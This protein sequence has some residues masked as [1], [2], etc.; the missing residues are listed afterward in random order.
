MTEKAPISDLSRFTQRAVRFLSTVNHKL[1]DKKPAFSLNNDNLNLVLMSWKDDPQHGVEHSFNVYQ[2]MKEINNKEKLEIA[3][4]ELFLRAILHDFGEFIPF[5]R[6]DKEISRSDRSSKHHKYMWFMILVAA[7]SLDLNQNELAIDI[8]HHD[9]FYRGLSKEQI[10]HT[11]NSISLA[12]QVL[13]DADKLAI[14]SDA[15]IKRN[16]IGSLGK[17]YFLRQDLTDEERKKWQPRKGGLYDGFSALVREFN[18]PD[19]G[20]YTEIGKKLFN[21]RK[22]DFKEKLAEY[23]KHEYLKGWE[24]LDRAQTEH[25]WQI[26][27]ALKDKDEIIHI[28][29]RQLPENFSEMEIREQI[30]NITKIPVIKKSTP[31][32]KYFGY[33]IRVTDPSGVQTWLDPSILNYENLQELA[34]NLIKAVDEFSA[35]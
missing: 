22:T 20:I 11:K 16:R 33:S 2:L 4:S 7:K 15:T 31:E 10:Q 26:K 6:G 27:F 19:W 30:S 5:I 23:Y 28:P 3:D 14:D 1:C 25:G 35:S 24:I 18:G 32:R 34:K 29:E 9:D 13:S 12:G 17:W 21:E 8:F